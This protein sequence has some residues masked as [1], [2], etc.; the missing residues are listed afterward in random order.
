MYIHFQGAYSLIPALFHAV[1]ETMI[2]RSNSSLF[3]HRTVKE[4][5]WGYTDPMLKDTV[6]VFAPVSRFSIERY[7]HNVNISKMTKV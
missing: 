5:L 4:M 3:Q 7:W 6:G 1:L 2:K